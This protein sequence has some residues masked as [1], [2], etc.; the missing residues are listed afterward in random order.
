MSIRGGSSS[1]DTA[2]DKLPGLALNQ[3]KD[4]DNVLLW[5]SPR[6][7]LDAESMR[8]AMLFVSGELDLEPGALAVKLDTPA[9]RKPIS[10]SARTLVNRHGQASDAPRRQNK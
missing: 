1:A 10:V 2:P 5:R 6:R 7:R 8:D 3:T 9:F 4:P